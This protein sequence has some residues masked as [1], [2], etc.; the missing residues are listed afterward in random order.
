[1]LDE[2]AVNCWDCHE[3]CVVDTVLLIQEK[4]PDTFLAVLVDKSALGTTPERRVEHVH[5]SMNVMERQHV[6][7]MVVLG[8][9]PSFLHLDHHG[10]ERTMS[11]NHSFWVSCCA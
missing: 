8:P 4:V 7:D 6:H 11:V 1:M 3:N 10:L 2:L 5:D 9:S